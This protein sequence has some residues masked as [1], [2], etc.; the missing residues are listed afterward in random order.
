[1]TSLRSCVAIATAL[2][3]PACAGNHAAYSPP[4]SSSAASQPTPNRIRG[5]STQS[6][7]YIA[8]ILSSGGEIYGFSLPSLSMTYY[9]NTDLNEPEGI[10]VDAHGAI[11][12]ANTYGYNILKFKPPATAPVQKIRVRGYRP[13]DAAIDSKGN[14]WVAN[15]CTRRAK[16][17]PGNLQEYTAQG[18][19][20]H[21]LKCSNI[22]NFTFLAI[23]KNDNVVTDGWSGHSGGRA[24]EVRAGTTT[25]TPLTS[26]S[27]GGPGG[28]QFTPHGDLTIIDDINLVM[29]TYA[30]PNFSTLLSTTHMYGVPDAVED[31]FQPGGQ[32]F[33]TAVAGY[34][35]VFQFA[36][37]V[38]GNPTGSID[39]IYFP[40]GV[41]ITTKS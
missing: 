33:W 13:T 31:A 8:N 3:V 10:S 32:Y 2:L 28:V 5:A 40:S 30:K 21:T 16:C 1:M 22:K 19:K 29:V 34:N 25:C 9:T 38:G 17:A 35:G 15:Y 6:T 36:Y 4:V 41:A 20:L 23:D 39:N 24:A 7:I 18:Q 37:P 14:V 12:V 26:V 11:Y 27:F